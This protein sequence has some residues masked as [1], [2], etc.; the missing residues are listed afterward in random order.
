MGLNYIA[1]YIFLFRAQTKQ[2]HLLFSSAHSLQEGNE[3]HE[4]IGILRFT[5][6]V[7][8]GLGIWRKLL[9]KGGKDF[10]QLI[11]NHGVVIILVIQFK[12]FNKVMES[13][14]FLGVLA[15]LVH[16]VDLSL[17][18]HLLSLFS[19]SSNLIDGL[20]GWVQVAGTDEVT[21]IEGINSAVSLHVID[22]K[23]KFN[24]INLL[25]LKTEFSHCDCGSVVLIIV[26]YTL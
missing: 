11:S 15:G 21:S 18:E 17:G 3:G 2:N 5:E 9:S 6:L 4:T 25:L 23:C 13:S 10:E 8:E 19:L 22:I 20:E 16:G 1:R 12:D 7:H 24:C 26:L 14:L